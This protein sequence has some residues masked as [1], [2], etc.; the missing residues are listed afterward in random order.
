MGTRDI[1]DVYCPGCGFLN[2]SVYYAPTC[3]FLTCVCESCGT[4]IDLEAYT[5]ILVEDASNSQR[6][7]ALADAI[8]AYYDRRK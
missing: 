8:E 6:I 4:E 1:L 3:D 5:G 2:E 7:N